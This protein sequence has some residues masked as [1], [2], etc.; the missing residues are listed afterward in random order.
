[1]EKMFISIRTPNNL[2][3]KRKLCKS[4]GNEASHEALFD[5]GNGIT[6]VEKYCSICASTVGTSSS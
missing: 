3:G 1:M 5:V 2:N 6:V 4:C